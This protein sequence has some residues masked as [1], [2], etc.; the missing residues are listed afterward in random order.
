LVAYEPGEGDLVTQ[1]HSAL[2]RARASI[3]EG[4]AAA[5]L[6]HWVDACKRVPAPR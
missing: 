3:D 1:L 4:S 5:V 2:E 6:Q